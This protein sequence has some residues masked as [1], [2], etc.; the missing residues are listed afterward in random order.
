MSFP[1]FPLTLLPALLSAGAPSENCGER[2]RDKFIEDGIAHDTGGAF[3][4]SIRKWRLSSLEFDR[5]LLRTAFVTII[6][7]HR[8][9]VRIFKELDLELTMT[10]IHLPFRCA[11]LIQA[12]C[13]SLAFGALENANLQHGM[14]ARRMIALPATHRFATF[15]KRRIVVAHWA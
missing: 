10:A 7:R 4:L 9:A 12:N 11:I 13:S 5:Q 2:R 6:L 8:D 15:F 1:A 14:R 3:I